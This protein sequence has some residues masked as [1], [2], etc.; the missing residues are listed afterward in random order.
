[1]VSDVQ[2]LLSV[3]KATLVSTTRPSGDMHCRK[4][5]HSVMVLRKH[6]PGNIT[7]LKKINI[8]ADIEMFLRSECVAKSLCTAEQKLRPFLRKAACA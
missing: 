7:R 2:Y 8:S 4:H 3:D 6:I 5:V 1:M